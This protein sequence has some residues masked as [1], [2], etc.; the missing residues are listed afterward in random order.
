M[1]TKMKGLIKG[2][3][4]ISQI[5]ENEKEP[6]MQIGYPTDVKH[7]A[8]I[9]WDGPSVDS[10]SWMKEFP[11]SSQSAPL[12]INSESKENPEVKWVSGDSS[13]RSMRPQNSPV[14][15]SPDLPI[16]SR[17]H[18]TDGYLAA[19]SPSREPSTKQKSSSR[20][21]RHS[22]SNSK[23]SNESSKPSGVG[24][25][26]PGSEPGSPRTLLPDIPKKSTR[27]KKAKESSSGS[28]RT[29][30]S[31]AAAASSSTYTSPFSDPGAGGT[32]GELCQP[33]NLKPLVQE[34]EKGRYGIS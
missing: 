28:I 31:K 13:R 7:V 26:D 2:L 1:G 29:S 30:R 6:E 9:G 19:D 15:D 33:Q 25:Q 21:R 27:R 17:R 5:F 12:N 4:Y 18:S 8:H 14:I 11:G 10:P 32:G 34:D 22:K 24:V 20:L 23:E 3:R 16:S